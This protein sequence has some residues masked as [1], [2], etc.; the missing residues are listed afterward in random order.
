MKY[1]MLVSSP[2]GGMKTSHICLAISI[3]ISGVYFLSNLIII[4]SK[5][6]DIILGMD[7]LRKYGG[8]ISCTKRAIR[9]TQKDETIVEFIAAISTNQLSVINQV[10]GISLDEIRIIQNYPDVFPEE[11]PGMPPNRDIK[12]IIELL[13]QTPPISKRPYSLPR[14]EPLFSSLKRKMGLKECV[15]YRSLNEVTIKSKY[16][17]PQI[18]DLFDQMK[19]VSVFSKIDLRSGY[20]QLRI[21]ELD[22]AKIAFCTRY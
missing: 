20:H 19:G 2:G 3:A 21:R 5:G 15:D 12:F 13:P 11:V 22:I 14:G 4:D 8:M 16:P 17:L 6:I 9:L 7:W 18:K 10:K 1:T